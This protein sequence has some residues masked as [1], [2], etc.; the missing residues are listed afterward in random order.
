MVFDLAFFSIRG[1][2]HCPMSFV[3]T[4]VHGHAY[5]VV[6]SAHWRPRLGH[7]MIEHSDIP[8]RSHSGSCRSFRSQSIFL[9]RGC[10][11]A[12]CLI[13]NPTPR[14]NVACVAVQ[15]LFHI[16]LFH[17]GA[18]VAVHGRQAASRRAVNHAKGA[19][20]PL[21]TW[22]LTLW[23][24]TARTPCMAHV[25]PYMHSTSDV[26]VIITQPRHLISI[27]GLIAKFRD[28][29]RQARAVVANETG[30][31]APTCVFNANYK[32]LQSKEDTNEEYREAMIECALL[33]SEGVLLV[34]PLSGSALLRKT[35]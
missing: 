31:K 21:Y 10:M 22:S 17:S 23:I 19:N 27:K 1:L 14:S 13:G 12:V 25:H 18:Q 34:C 11:H 33:P 16:H 4:R 28:T 6:S 24:Y 32:T 35:N 26:R 5:L 15:Y 2:W 29:A 7:L 3:K 9:F 20:S 8:Y 30:A